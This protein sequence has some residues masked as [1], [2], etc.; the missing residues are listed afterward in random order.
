[1][2]RK[3]S[4]LMLAVLAVAGGGHAEKWHAATAGTWAQEGAM[5]AT[6][7]HHGCGCGCASCE[8]IMH[9]AEAQN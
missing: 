2:F 9:G 3:I 5:F 7:S 1:M 6:T 8:T 4:G